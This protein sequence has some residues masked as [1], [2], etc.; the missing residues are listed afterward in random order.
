MPPLAD[1]AAANRT[2]ANQIFLDWRPDYQLELPSLDPS[3]QGS[4]ADVAYL[5]EDSG[6][7]GASPW[8]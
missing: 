1:G 6:R 8:Y 3:K 7:A 5:E 2:E 4:R